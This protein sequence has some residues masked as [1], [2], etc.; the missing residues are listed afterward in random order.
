MHFQFLIEDRSGAELIN[1]LMEKIIN[2]RE[3]ITFNCKS[4]K[5]LGGFTKKNV[6]HETKTGCLLNDLATYL[7]GFNKSLQ[8]FPS[9]I[10][11]VLDNDTRNPQDFRTE[12]ENVARTNGITLDYVFCIAIEEMEAWLLG[13]EVALLSAYPFAK[14]QVLQRYIQ[15]SICGTWEKLADAVYPGGL[16]RMKK[17]CPT[18]VEIGKQKSEWAKRIGVFMDINRNESHS[19]QFFLNAIQKRIPVIAS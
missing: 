13:D 9:T 16:A 12:L 14:R 11:V 2:G 3:D 4:F 19:F 18:F 17:E 10:I 5:G 1:I 6:T 15:D 8:G 7:R